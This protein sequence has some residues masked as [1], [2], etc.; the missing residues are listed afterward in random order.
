VQSREIVPTECAAEAGV[1]AS[2]PHPSGSNGLPSVG[3]VSGESEKSQ[4]LMVEA[5]G[6][7]CGLRVEVSALEGISPLTTAIEDQATTVGDS[8]QRLQ[9]EIAVDGAPLDWTRRREELHAEHRFATTTHDRET[10]LAAYKTLMDRVEKHIRPEDLEEFKEL[11]RQDYNLLLFREGM[12][13]NYTD[14]LDTHVMAAITSREV[15]AGRMSPDDGLHKLAVAGSVIYGSQPKPH[16]LPKLS[17]MFGMLDYRAYKLLWLIC[18]PLRLAMWIAAWGL[19]VIAIMF[20]ASLDYSVLVRIVIAYAIWEGAAILLMIARRI[21][22]WFIK[23]GFFWL[24]DIVPAKA[25]SVEEAKAMVVGGPMTWLNKKFLNDFGNWTEDDTEQ[26][27]SL[28]NWRAKLIFHSTDRIHKRIRRFQELYRN[29]GKQPGD[30]T[31]QERQKVVA[32]LDYSWFE[33]AIIHPVAF[34]A[35]VRAIIIS[36]AMVSLDNSV[37][38]KWLTVRF[39]ST[40]P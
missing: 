1:E 2:P 11:R 3:C 6:P 17:I 21:L 31:E 10:L 4:M 20:S 22:F 23:K 28:M 36:I 8:L 40:R 24:V 29:T 27:A 12:I 7:E 5:K 25:E 13:G 39:M 18:L 37:A 38:I 34:D 14:I 33:K 26:L 30:L 9:A 19:V 15:A 32:D 35:M 16:K